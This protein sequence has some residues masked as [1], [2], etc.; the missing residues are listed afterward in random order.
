MEADFEALIKS[1]IE[2]K[3]GISDT[4]LNNVL[5]DQLKSNLLS[6]H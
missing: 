3:I 5:A 6:L 1:F 4:F 2:T